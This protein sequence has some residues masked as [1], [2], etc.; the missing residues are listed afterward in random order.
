MKRRRTSRRKGGGGWLLH[1]GVEWGVRRCYTVVKMCEETSCM[2]M[3]I[4]IEPK[5]K[6]YIFP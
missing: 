2:D 4:T 3:G 6:P 1:P 5:A